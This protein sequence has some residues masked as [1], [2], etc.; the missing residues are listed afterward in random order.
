VRLRGQV[1]LIDEDQV[2]LVGE[3]FLGAGLEVVDAR[4]DNVV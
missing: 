2:P 3:D 1:R 4:D